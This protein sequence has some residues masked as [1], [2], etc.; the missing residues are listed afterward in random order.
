M[1]FNAIA[2]DSLYQF[3]GPV[4]KVVH[5]FTLIPLPNKEFTT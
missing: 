3:G 4:P 1:S 5:G 2:I